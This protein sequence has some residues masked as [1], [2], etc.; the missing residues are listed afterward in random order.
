[1]KNEKRTVLIN[2]SGGSLKTSVIAYC[3]LRM[4][5]EPRDRALNLIVMLKMENRIH[6]GDLRFEFAEK[7]IVPLLIEKEL[8]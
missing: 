2:S 1:M 5:G 8:I 7:K 4:S 3:L 6:F